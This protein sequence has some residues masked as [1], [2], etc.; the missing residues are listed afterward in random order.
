ML[1]NYIIRSDNYCLIAREQ[2][3]LEKVSINK[4]VCISHESSESTLGALLKPSM[5]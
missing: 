3:S 4:Q 2:T 1:A 5:R